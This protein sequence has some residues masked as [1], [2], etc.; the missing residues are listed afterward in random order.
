MPKVT[1]FM[2]DLLIV[3]DDLEL[4]D[5]LERLLKRDGYEVK[6]AQSAKEALTLIR[7]SIPNLIV[8]DAIMPEMDGI[9]LC[10]QL[11]DYSPTA[12]TPIIMLTGTQIDGHI[13]DALNAGADDYIRKPFATRELL[14]RVRAHLRRAVAYDNEVLAVIQIDPDHN[15]VKVNERR[16]TLTRVEYELLRYMARSPHKLHG[17]DRLLTDVWNYPP[18]VGDAALVRNHI[19]NLRQ[20]IE[21]D[22]DR[23]EIIQSRH[24]RG[25]I[26]KA[27]VLFEE[28]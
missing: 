9:T 20:K 19:H 11:R 21:Q 17:I 22:A 23:P 12:T 16:V 4:L 27:H 25:Y 13:V 24:G 7:D 6:R 14:A 3:D 26:I 10:R 28:M 2:H 15:Y 5:L 1:L 18:G 8:I